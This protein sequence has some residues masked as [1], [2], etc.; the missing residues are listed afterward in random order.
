MKEETGISFGQLEEVLKRNRRNRRNR[1]ND[2][3][4]KSLKYRKHT[5]TNLASVFAN[6]WVCQRHDDD[7]HAYVLSA[8]G[9]ASTSTG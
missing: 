2:G 9:A 1:T 8:G 7:P 6:V 5:S 4:E 3:R